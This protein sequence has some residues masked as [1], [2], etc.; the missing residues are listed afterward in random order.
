MRPHVHVHSRRC[1]VCQQ[2]FTPKSRA[3]A[4]QITCSSKCRKKYRGARA[5]KR[6]LE[7]LE[8]YR[9]AELVR[10]H[11]CREKKDEAREATGPPRASSEPSAAS[12]RLIEQILKQGPRQSSATLRKALF[13]LV[14]LA[15]PQAGT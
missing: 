5:Q 3:A 4:A 8:A 13:D 15:G 6:R 1:A 11:R 9:A 7:K 10:Q 14:R 12:L 2:W